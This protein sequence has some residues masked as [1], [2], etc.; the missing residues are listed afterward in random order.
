MPRRPSG[1]RWWPLCRRRWTGRRGGDDDLP[2]E[3]DVNG[4]SL[5]VNTGD[6]R[7]VGLSV[8]SP[9]SQGS[10]PT[11]PIV[12]GAESTPLSP[13]P[14]SSPFSATTSLISPSFSSTLTLRG[15]VVN[16]SR[17][18]SR[19]SMSKE[20]AQLLQRE[21]APPLASPPSASGNGAGA[22]GEFVE[23][24]RDP[25]P[26]AEVSPVLGRGVYT[27]MSA[28]L[29]SFIAGA[30]LT[31]TL[32]VPKGVWQQVGRKVQAY[33]IKVDCWETLHEQLLALPHPP[34]SALTA[35]ATKDA[36]DAFLALHLVLEQIH[37][38]LAQHLPYLPSPQPSRARRPPLKSPFNTQALTRLLSRATD[39]ASIGARK[40]DEVENARYCE[41]ARGV[42]EG[43]A[44]MRQW[45]EWVER[46]RGVGGE[47]VGGLEGQMAAVDEWLYTV[48]V[49]V[50]LHD[51]QVGVAR[52]MKHA[53]RGL[54]GTRTAGEGKWTRAGANAVASITAAANGTIT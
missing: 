30:A 32:Y 45:H 7:S 47:G 41:A 10:L 50:L 54:K 49:S 15:P 42:L 31:A 35:E 18:R 6:S 38:R 9:L 20:F 4:H 34:L 44:V 25:R 2:S 14:G 28:L 51:L 24:P 8:L 5:R 48:F 21:R 53:F 52:Y 16:V 37:E 23:L 13:Q 33:A 17:R 19:R 29:S 46:W 36:D 22:L 1:T 26:A 40:L 39:A 3:A 27:L 11:T 12:G 43:V